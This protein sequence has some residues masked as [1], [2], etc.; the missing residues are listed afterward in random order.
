MIPSPG[1][2]PTNVAMS[3]GDALELAANED[4]KTTDSLTNSEQKSHLPSSPQAASSPLV[5]KVVPEE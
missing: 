4:E 5:K 3:L 2:T 1:Q